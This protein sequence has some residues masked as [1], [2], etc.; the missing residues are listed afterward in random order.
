[1]PDLEPEQ[2]SEPVQHVYNVYVVKQHPDTQ[3]EPLSPQFVEDEQSRPAAPAPKPTPRKPLLQLLLLVVVLVS[4]VGGIIAGILAPMLVVP[5]VPVTI[6]PDQQTITTTSTIPLI[7]GS[8]SPGQLH[9]RL[10]PSYTIS[11]QQTVPTTGTGHTDAKA[12]IGTITLY[13]AAPYSQSIPAGTL[14]IAPDGVQVITNETVVLP[15][16]NM[17]VVGQATVSGHAASVGPGGNIPA[18]AINGACCRLNVF[19]KNTR[20]FTGG[21]DARVFPMVSQHDLDTVTTSLKISLQQ[22]IDAALQT[23]LKAN[24]AAIT[25]PSCTPTPTSDHPVGSEASSVTVTVSMSCRAQA[26]EKDNL[27]Q[28]LIQSQTQAAHKLLGTHYLLLGSIVPAMSHITS[29]T[30]ETTTLTVQGTGVWVYQFT[31]EQLHA[32]ARQIA[33]KP[34][35]KATALL[36]QHPGI[37]QVSVGGTDAILPR[38]PGTIHIAVLSGTMQLIN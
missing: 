35:D 25:L 34:K 38:D 33:G 23:Q 7:S 26:Y 14:L 29:S 11:E 27:Q 8:P 21:Q 9:V 15:A 28:L 16:A 19:A 32:L 1:M 36:L 22:S 13:N 30:H 4:A 24:E 31:Q 37:S 12:A 17:P 2:H 20:G 5:A 18:L 10:L 3:E 6:I